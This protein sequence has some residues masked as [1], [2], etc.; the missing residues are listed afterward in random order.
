M[1]DVDSGVKSLQWAQK[2]RHDELM[3]ELGQ[4]RAMV[5][6]GTS[7]VQ[8]NTVTVF[9]GLHFFGT[10]LLIQFPYFQDSGEKTWKREGK[11]GR[12]RTSL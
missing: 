12:F 7:L 2:K 3:D 1:L 6:K 9:V 8:C 10:K 11:E 4:L 5:G